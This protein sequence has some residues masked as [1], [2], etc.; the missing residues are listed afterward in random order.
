MR[1]WPKWSSPARGCMFVAALSLSAPAWGQSGDA[2]ASPPVEPSGGEAQEEEPG[3]AGAAAASPAAPEPEPPPPPPG[4][5]ALTPSQR[6]PENLQ[7]WM[8]ERRRRNPALVERQPVSG[9]Q[10]T[11]V[12][13]LDED[14]PTVEVLKRR[15]RAFNEGGVTVLSNRRNPTGPIAPQ[16]TRVGAEAAVARPSAAPAD[17]P[18]TEEPDP[19]EER[20]VHDPAGDSHVDARPADSEGLAGDAPMVETRSLRTRSTRAAPRAEDTSPEWPAW[21]AVCAALG[22]VVVW[23]RKRRQ[24]AS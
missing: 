7:G 24:P 8:R 21:L 20:A 3:A 5:K 2:G 18:A 19:D 16:V 15:L 23:L 10:S 17:G 1:S 4:L 13:R 11:V 9:T 12:P 22:L 6:L 14:D